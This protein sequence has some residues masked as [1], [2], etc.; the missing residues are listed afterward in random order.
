MLNCMLSVCML[1]SFHFTLSLQAHTREVYAK[2]FQTH[3][4]NL[5]K[6]IVHPNG[7]CLVQNTY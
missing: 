6:K 7:N 3:F 5:H 4:Y 1:P 2:V